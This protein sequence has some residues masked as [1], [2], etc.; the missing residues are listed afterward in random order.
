[1]KVICIRTSHF[2]EDCFAEY[3]E[4]HWTC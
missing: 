2:S 1:M 3:E 4:R